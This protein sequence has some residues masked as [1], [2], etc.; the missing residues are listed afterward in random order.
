MFERV[1]TSLDVN[2]KCI[3]I[4]CILPRNVVSLLRVLTLINTVFG[5]LIHGGF[6]CGDLIPGAFNCNE[7]KAEKK[8]NHL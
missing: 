4:I 7:R 3:E 2:M 1:W 5:D 6:N 8:E